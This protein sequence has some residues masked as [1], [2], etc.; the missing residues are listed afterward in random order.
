MPKDLQA[1]LS[2]PVIKD[3]LALQFLDE[4]AY[5]LD[6]KMVTKGLGQSQPLLA[7]SFIPTSDEQFFQIFEIFSS[8][9]YPYNIRVSSQSVLKEVVLFRVGMNETLTIPGDQAVQERHHE[10]LDQL[11]AVECSY[12]GVVLA[13]IEKIEGKV[14]RSRL[15]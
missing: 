15:H 3:E 13:A 5:G 14:D 2:F 9:G 6:S 8:M 7:I 1:V 10:G 12:E 11:L 4:L